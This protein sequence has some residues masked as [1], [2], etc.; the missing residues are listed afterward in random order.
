LDYAIEDLKIFFAPPA[1]TVFVG[2][3]CDEGGLL[4]AFVFF[5]MLGPGGLD[6]LFTL[7]VFFGTEGVVSTLL[8]VFIHGGSERIISLEDDEVGSLHA[9]R[10]LSGFQAEP[11]DI[12]SHEILTLRRSDARTM[13]EHLPITRQGTIHL[14]EAETPGVIPPGDNPASA[15]S[16]NS[17]TLTHSSFI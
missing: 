5:V 12:A 14:D 7:L 4:A 10:L 3:G 16:H 1:P 13:D 15:K 11:D 9:T 6:S 8:V 2:A 17:P